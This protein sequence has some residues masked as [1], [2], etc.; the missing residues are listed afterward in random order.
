[1][2]WSEEGC[3]TESFPLGDVLVYLTPQREYSNGFSILVR[4]PNRIVET[5]KRSRS[6]LGIFKKGKYNLIFVRN[7]VFDGLLAIY[8]KRKYKIPLV[9]ELSSPL[10]QEWESFKIEP[11][12][13]KLLYYL[14][15]NL[16]T[17]I[18][19]YIMK[20]ADLI[21]PT[22]R[23]FEEGLISRGIVASK[24]M[25]YPNGVDIESFSSKDG[26]DICKKY[27]LSNS[28]VIIYIGIMD[29][30]RYLD[31]LIK[32]FSKV[33]GEIGKVML[34]MVG[35]GN[36]RENLQRLVEELGLSDDVIF[37]GQVPQSD[38]PNFIAAA[39]IGVSPVPPLSFYKV[40]SPIKMLEYMAIGKPVVA[41]EEIFEH[42]EVLE[43]SGGGILVPFTP[44][45]FAE[46]MI[47]LLGN[48]EKAVEMGRRGGEWVTKNRSFEVLARR[49]EKRYFE[50]LP[51]E[52]SETN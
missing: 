22:T 26:E 20:K 14:M 17:L 11:K 7:S 13:P 50:I 16:T 12:K 1:M 36:D 18:R 10:E 51:G 40:S 34:L 39:D 38:V 37:T 6:I 8:I 25:P 15:A 30:V 3:Q 32:A 9:F 4:I 48:P 33:K 27:L 2:I 19:V 29:K 23:W 5:V 46:A 45:A 43:E 24:L 42:K 21:L 52:A 35:E 41:N 31:V 28:K 44:E 49:L 47:E